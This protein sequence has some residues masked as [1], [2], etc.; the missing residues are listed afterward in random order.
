MKAIV[1][2][3]WNVVKLPLIWALNIL[4]KVVKIVIEETIFLLETIKSFLN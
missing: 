3:V 4:K 2:K 1:L